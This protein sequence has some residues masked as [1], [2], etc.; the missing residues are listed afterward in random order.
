M[1]QFHAM[2]PFYLI[3]KT[4]KEIF[5]FLTI[6]KHLNLKICQNCKQCMYIFEFISKFNSYINI[7]LSNK[8]ESFKTHLLMYFGA[9]TT[10]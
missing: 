8:I 4:F 5:Q 3:L 2:F 1:L 10:T 9:P 6:A 7:S